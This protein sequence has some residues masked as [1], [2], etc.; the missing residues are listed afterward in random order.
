[1]HGVASRRWISAEN[2]TPAQI[3][4]KSRALRTEMEHN[5]QLPDALSDSEPVDVIPGI[6]DQVEFVWQAIQC[7]KLEIPDTH[8]EM[9][10]DTTLLFENLTSESHAIN[11]VTVN[12][13]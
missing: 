7:W 8:E 3:R 12:N 11:T 10:F 9:S 2:R 1:M 5:P 6:R 4:V 13:L